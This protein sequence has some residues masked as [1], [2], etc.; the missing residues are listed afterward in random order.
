MKPA[1]IAIVVARFM[2]SAAGDRS[3]MLTPQARQRNRK[4]LRDAKR[5][6][7]ALTYR[8]DERRRLAEAQ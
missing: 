3:Q 4:I 1:P 2:M 7:K 5:A 8:L 6:R